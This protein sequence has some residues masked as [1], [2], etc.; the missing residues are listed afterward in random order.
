LCG[1]GEYGHATRHTALASFVAHFERRD[2]DGS[3]KIA[4]KFFPR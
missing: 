2:G 1:S 4:G 3:V